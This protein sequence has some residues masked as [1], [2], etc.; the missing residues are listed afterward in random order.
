MKLEDIQQSIL[1]AANQFELGRGIKTISVDKIFQLD[2]IAY[3]T[4]FKSDGTKSLFIAVRLAGKRN[5]NPD[6]SWRW[7]C[8]DELQA[9][10]LKTFSQFYDEIQ[11][12]NRKNRKG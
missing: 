5:P 3:F 10:G 2:G 11:N 4:G 8:P 6:N 1:N 9:T 12:F 7:F